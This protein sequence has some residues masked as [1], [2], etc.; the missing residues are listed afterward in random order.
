MMGACSRFAGLVCQ[1]LRLC[2]GLQPRSDPKCYGENELVAC[3]EGVLGGET[4]LCLGWPTAFNP[5]IDSKAKEELEIAQSRAAGRPNN[6]GLYLRQTCRL[7][8]QA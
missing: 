7:H 1:T 8:W 5:R 3:C 4:W 6:A 2:G